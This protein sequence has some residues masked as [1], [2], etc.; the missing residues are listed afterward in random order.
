MGD[1]SNVSAWEHVSCIE[2]KAEELKASLMRTRHT[3]SD[4]ILHQT[5]PLVRPREEIAGHTSELT[6]SLKMAFPEV[7]LRQV[8]WEV[9]M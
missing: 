1:E 5:E 4:V 7:A 6:R 9:V 2:P 3:M 8:K